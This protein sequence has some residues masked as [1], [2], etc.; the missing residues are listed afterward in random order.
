MVVIGTFSIGTDGTP[1]IE[2]LDVIP[3]NER[4]VPA[5][6]DPLSCSST[7]GQHHVESARR[8]ARPFLY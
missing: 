3:M 8:V 5:A 7:A 2:Q 1:T 6:A 4:W